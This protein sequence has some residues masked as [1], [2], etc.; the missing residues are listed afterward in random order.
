MKTEKPLFRLIDHTADLGMA[1]RGR[2]LESLFER[3]GLSLI[4][5]M[6][7][8]VP[9]GPHMLRSVNITAGDLTDLMV[10]WLGEIL[11]LFEGEGEILSAVSIEKLTPT[12]MDT[13]LATV[14][15]DPERHEILREIKAVTYHKA[16]VRRAGGHY[17]SRIFFDL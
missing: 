8:S 2:D 15:F 4:G 5:I 7:K 12:R 14:S 1:V 17:V 10:R 6:L 9:P 13:T 16:S 11:Y 3:A